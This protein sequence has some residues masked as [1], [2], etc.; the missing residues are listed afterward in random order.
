MSLCNQLLRTCSKVKI[1]ERRLR[2]LG[3]GSA[4]PSGAH[5]THPHLLPCAF[6]FCDSFAL[7][8]T[9]CVLIIPHTHARA[10]TIPSIITFYTF[11]TNYEIFLPF[12]FPNEFSFVLLATQERELL[13]RIITYKESYHS[14]KLS[15]SLTNYNMLIAPL[16]SCGVSCCLFL[17]LGFLSGWG[18]CGS[19]VFCHNNCE[20]TCSCSVVSRT[21]CFHEFC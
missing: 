8:N 14:R 17:R 20:F 10:H 2:L 15:P 21:H 16:A 12:S 11:P 4:P 19:Y 5:S 7:Y 3:S 1:V 9:Q 18:L 6:F 13:W